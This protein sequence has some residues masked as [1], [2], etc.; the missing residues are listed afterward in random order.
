M[1]DRK[2]LLVTC[3]NPH[4]KGWLELR[5]ALWPHCSRGEHLEEMARFCAEPDRF[6]QFLAR[7]PEDHAVGL[8]EVALRLDY[9]NGTKASP[10]AFLEGIY[11]RPE[12][13]RRGIARFLL[14]H[15]EKCA[16]ARGCREFASDAAIT[17]S[18]SH[19]MHKALGFEET[20]RVVFFRKALSR[21]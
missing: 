12:A 7:T 10:A 9:V 4:E 5:A 20:E 11:V 16:S 8:V 17:N 6:A 19:A 18:A 2:L 21:Q 1:E 15:A 3:T 14:V 13:R